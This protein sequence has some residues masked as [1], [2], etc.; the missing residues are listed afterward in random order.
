MS[1]LKF[2]INSDD[3]ISLED[4]ENEEEDDEDYDN[5]EQQIQ[6]EFEDGIVINS[7]FFSLLFS[8]FP[9]L[10]LSLLSYLFVYFKGI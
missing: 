3:E 2:T 8:S 10:L 7:S 9:S 5:K 6:F 4:E 1:N